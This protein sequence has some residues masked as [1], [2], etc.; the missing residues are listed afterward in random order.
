[1][2]QLHHHKEATDMASIEIKG[3]YKHARSSS[4]TITSLLTWL[5]KPEMYL[6]WL[7]HIILVPVEK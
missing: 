7:S 6:C 4:E 2:A 3:T 5:I 1:M